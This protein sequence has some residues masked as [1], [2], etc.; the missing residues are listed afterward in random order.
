MELDACIWNYFPARNQDESVE[1]TNYIYQAVNLTLKA[2]AYYGNHCW[3]IKVLILWPEKPVPFLIDWVHLSMIPLSSSNLLKRCTCC[4]WNVLS[5]GRALIRMENWFDSSSQQGKWS[6][7]CGVSSPENVIEPVD[8]SL[9]LIWSPICFLWKQ[10]YYL[11][12]SLLVLNLLTNTTTSIRFD[13]ATSP[14]RY[15]QSTAP[16]LGERPANK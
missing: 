7:R 6:T 14:C 1:P 16:W 12:I 5:E 15:C 11:Y 8:V 10:F 2:S 9:S 4:R 3:V 13:P